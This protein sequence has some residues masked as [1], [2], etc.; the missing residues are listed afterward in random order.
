MTLN[1]EHG[2]TDIKTGWKHIKTNLRPAEIKVI[3]IEEG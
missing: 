3:M 1:V 2:N